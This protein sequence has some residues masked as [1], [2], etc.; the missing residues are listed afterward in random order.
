M[1]GLSLVDP[2]H[3][4]HDSSCSCISVREYRYWTDV[5]GLCRQDDLLHLHLDSLGSLSFTHFAMGSQQSLSH[6]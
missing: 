1:H 2:H 6:R 4:V 5:V 3:L